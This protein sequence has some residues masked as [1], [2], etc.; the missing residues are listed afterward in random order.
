EINQRFTRLESSLVTLAESIAKLSAQ[1]QMQRVIK[2][3]V[4]QLRQEVAELRQQ[5]NQCIRQQSATHISTNGITL[6]TPHQPSRLINANVQRAATANS[7]TP[8]NI[9]TSY[10]PSTSTIHRS[11]SIIDPRQARKIEQFF[12]TEAMLRY[13]LSLLNYEQ[14]APMLEQ[15]KI[16]IYELPYISERKL[17]SLGIPYGPCTRMIQEAQQYFIS[18]LTL[19]SSGIDV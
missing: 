14:Y 13:F 12:G 8:L 10:M 11:S 15:E 7:T 3:D 5:L 9:S 19:R 4:N 16:G 1:I 17:Q 6:S 2:D 18:L